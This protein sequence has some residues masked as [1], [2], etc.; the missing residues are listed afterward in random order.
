MATYTESKNAKQ[1]VLRSDSIVDLA[2][3]LQATKAHKWYGDRE[4]FHGYR[5]QWCGIDDCE[6]AGN[7]TQGALLSIGRDMAASG[8]AEGVAA[9]QKLAKESGPEIQADFDAIERSRVAPAYVGIPD[10]AKV[11]RGHP[12]AARRRTRLPQALPVIKVLI[13]LGGLGSVAGEQKNAFG[14]AA[15]A[16]IQRVQMTGTAVEITGYTKARA[17]NGST[18]E[19]YTLMKP[20]NAGLNLSLLAFCLT[21]PAY[22]RVLVFAARRRHSKHAFGHGYGC[23]IWDRPK[24]SD[25]MLYLVPDYSTNRRDVVKHYK[26]VTKA[27]KGHGSL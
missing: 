26:A 20:A 12:M 1:T 27:F 6:K 17:D 2:D 8:W 4:G 15:L 11:L 13:N 3:W 24:D 10:V 25:D 19:V 5:P 16:A 7:D 23:T 18:H 14:V 21:S 9:L 22:H